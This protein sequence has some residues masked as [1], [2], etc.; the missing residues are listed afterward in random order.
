MAGYS[1]QAARN[2]EVLPKIPVAV[3]SRTTPFI[4]TK[5]SGDTSSQFW[6]EKIGPKTASGGDDSVFRKLE[7]QAFAA[8]RVH[9]NG[10]PSMIGGCLHSVRN[11]EKVHKLGEMCHPDMTHGTTKSPI[12]LGRTL[13]G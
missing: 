5:P 11:A 2:R 4:R 9:S 12:A 3:P 1:G 8:R 10:L 13:P 7:K 6:H